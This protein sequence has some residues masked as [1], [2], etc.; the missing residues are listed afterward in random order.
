MNVSVSYK[1][2]GVEVFREEKEVADYQDLLAHLHSLKQNVNS[3][4]F[5]EHSKDTEQECKKKKTN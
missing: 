5:N 1:E 4:V 2:K 3:Q